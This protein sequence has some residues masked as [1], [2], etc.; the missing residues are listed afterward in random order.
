MLESGETIYDLPMVI[1]RE[2]S[3]K[4]LVILIKIPG[5]CADI[6]LIIDGSKLNQDGDH[7][8]IIFE[9]SYDRIFFGHRKD[10]RR[11]Y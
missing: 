9:T 3:W 5:F 6:H 10:I 8:G 7:K 11:R 1:K 2:K 4:L